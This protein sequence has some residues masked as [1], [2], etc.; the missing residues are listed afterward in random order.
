MSY[1]ANRHG[2]TLVE[3]MIVV[4]IIGIIASIAV[5]A[6]LRYIK[7]S[8]AAEADGI[9]TKITDGA[10]AYFTSEQRFSPPADGDQPWHLAGPGNRKEGFPVPFAEYAFPGGSSMQVSTA[11]PTGIGVAT[12]ADAPQGGEKMIPFQGSD[13]TDPM[14]VATW[15]KLRVNFKDPMYFAYTYSSN[16]TGAAANVE[17]VALANFDLQSPEAHTF[18]RRVTVDGGSQEVVIAPGFTS[19]EFQ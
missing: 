13:P 9:V 6:F 17:I 11:F 1:R 10:K 2:F 12:A 5:P 14:A 7:S 4:A 3:L 19:N 16:S 15:N 8:K 18:T